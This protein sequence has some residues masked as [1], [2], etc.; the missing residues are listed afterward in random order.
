[1][2]ERI[3]EVISCLEEL[4]EEFDVN[5]QLK[6]KASKV[7]SILKGDSEMAA[8]KALIELEELS[9]LDLPS[10]CRTQLWDIVSLLEKAKQ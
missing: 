8:E 6:E 4:H 9:T 7:I 3:K 5:R 10:Y 1:M 2:N